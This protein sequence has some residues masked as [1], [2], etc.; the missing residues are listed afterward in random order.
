MIVNENGWE[1]HKAP[2]KQEK[3]VAA[4]VK[5]AKKDGK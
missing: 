2:V 1:N 4:P 3:P 5:K